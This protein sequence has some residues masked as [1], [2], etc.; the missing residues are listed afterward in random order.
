MGAVYRKTVTKPMPE[1]AE[2][3]TRKGQQFARWR[4]ASGK[5]RTA[6][7]TNGRDGQ[8]RI[9]LTARTYT[10]KYRDG[11]DIVRE[12]ATGCRDEQAARAILNDLE[13]R[14]VRV[15][16]RIV[17]AAED[18]VIDHQATSLAEHFQAYRE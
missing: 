18:R 17:S 15:K 10:A 5:S 14:A 2:V 11:Q 8:P 6:E 3:F 12:V 13:T 9:V 4:D 1:G 7:M 16:A